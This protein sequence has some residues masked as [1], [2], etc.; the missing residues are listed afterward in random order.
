MR[1]FGVILPDKMVFRY[2]LRR[3][4][5]IGAH[6]AKVIC[7]SMEIDDSVRVKNLSDSHV[8]KLR[9]VIDDFGYVTGVDLQKIVSNNIKRLQAN[10][11][12]RGRRHFYSLP[13]RG[14]R[15]QSNAKSARYK[16]GRSKSKS[17]VARKKV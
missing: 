11:S 12:L 1:V 6:R 10:G 13:V 17:T 15:T 14:Q 2:A 9:E 5:G 16:F 8:V 3:I 4:Y 7:D